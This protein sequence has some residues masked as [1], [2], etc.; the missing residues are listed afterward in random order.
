MNWKVTKRRKNDYLV[1]CYGEKKGICRAYTEADATRIATAL[2][3]C[4]DKG[5]IAVI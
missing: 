3:I 5:E 2:T 1:H 4:N